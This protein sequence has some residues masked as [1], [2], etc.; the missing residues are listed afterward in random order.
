MIPD[1]ELI[2][3][4]FLRAHPAV[5]AL[6]A[7]V[8]PEVPPATER[9]WVQVR[10]I[11]AFAHRSLDIEWLIDFTLQ[12][13]CC[14]GRAGDQA[15]ANLLARTVR[16]ALE[17]MPGRRDDAVVVRTRVLSDPRIPDT[18]FEPAMQRRVLTVAIRMHR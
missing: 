4:R 11:N 10:Q 16:A 2:V 15:T 14:A 18:S 7:G 9:P 8:V 3:G 5:V 13:D 1:A 12:L 6:G 17:E